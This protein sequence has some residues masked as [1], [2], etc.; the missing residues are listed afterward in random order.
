VQHPPIHPTTANQVVYGSA[1]ANISFEEIIN[2][3]DEIF[4][5]PG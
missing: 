3:G 4:G 1:Q 5:R 2:Q